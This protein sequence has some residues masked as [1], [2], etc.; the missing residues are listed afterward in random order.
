MRSYKIAGV[1]V[2]MDTFGF[3]YDRGRPYEIEYTAEPDITIE[4][5]WEDLKKAHPEVHEFFCEYTSTGSDFYEKLLAFDGMLLHSSAVVMDG[6]AYL[7][8]ADSGTG[9]S[10]H[11]S[12]YRRYYGDDRVRIL[13]DDK[14]AIR[15][16]DGIFYAYGTPWSGKTDLNLNLRVP[17]AGVCLLERGEKN[18][19]AP[20]PAGKAL[21]RLLQQTRRFDD[22]VKM[23]KVMMLLDALLR[24]VPVWIMKC[25]MDPE[26]ARVSYE[27][28]SGKNN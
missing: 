9:K 14:P 21:F 3:A 28:M 18:E 13:N 8:S 10:T 11:T 17:L 12:L 27:A 16:E 23:D 15:L 26:A 19:I 22:K 5:H 6:K 7:F 4:S 1:T 20:L 24:K 25:N 2:N